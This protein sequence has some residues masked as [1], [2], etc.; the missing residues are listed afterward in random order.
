MSQ[1]NSTFRRG[2]VDLLKLTNVYA[3]LLLT[4]TWTYYNVYLDLLLTSMRS[5]LLTQIAIH[6]KV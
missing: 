6:G 2:N 3:D 1:Y 5:Y 4:S